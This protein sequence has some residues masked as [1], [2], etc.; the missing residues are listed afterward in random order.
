MKILIFR[1]KVFVIKLIQLIQSIQT[2]IRQFY[3]K[4]IQDLRYF[5]ND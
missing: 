2:I 5:L 4:N 3:R 1:R